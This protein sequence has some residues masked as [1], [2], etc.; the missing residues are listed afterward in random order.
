MHISHSN[1][2]TDKLVDLTVKSCEGLCEL[3]ADFKQFKKNLKSIK[4]LSVYV[5]HIEEEGDEIYEEA[6]RKLFDENNKM[7]MLD[8]IRLQN[9][10]NTMEDAL[11]YCEDVADIAE[12][13]IISNT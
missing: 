3:M 8:V 4:K 10:Y 13:I 9:L 1:E 5:N 6:M 7:N 2:T 12:Q 11:D